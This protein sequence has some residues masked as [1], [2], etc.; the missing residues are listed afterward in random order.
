MIFFLHSG[1]INFL[2]HYF[3][4]YLRPRIKNVNYEK[5]ISNQLICIFCNNK[6]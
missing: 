6:L 1:Q 3:I 2:S 4:V 5:I